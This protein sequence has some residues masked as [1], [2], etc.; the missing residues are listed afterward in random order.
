MTQRFQVSIHLVEPGNLSVIDAY[1]TFI[2]RGF[3]S[4]RIRLTSVGSHDAALPGSAMS[5]IQKPI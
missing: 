1:S 5:V 2:Q 4:R 3:L